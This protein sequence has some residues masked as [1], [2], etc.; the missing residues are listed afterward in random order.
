M[1]GTC[2]GREWVAEVEFKPVVMPGRERG[3]SEERRPAAALLA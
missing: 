1:Y 2:D 3:T